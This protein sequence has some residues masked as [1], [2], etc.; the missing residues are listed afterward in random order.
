MRIQKNWVRTKPVKDKQEV[1]I[2]KERVPPKIERTH[3]R[4]I[5][6]SQWTDTTRHQSRE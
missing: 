2:T 5:K 3:P 1:L 6:R 4:N